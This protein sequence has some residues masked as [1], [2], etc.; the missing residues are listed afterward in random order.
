MALHL[1]TGRRYTAAAIGVERRTN[2]TDARPWVR[3]YGT[4]PAHLDYPEITLYE[5]LARTAQRVPHAIAWDFFDTTSTFRQL[6]ADIDHFADALAATGLKRGERMLISM[7]TSPQGVIAFY[8]ANKLGAVA[9]VIHPLST[10]PEIEGYLDASRARIALTL[11]AFYER[12]ASAQPRV[13]L[14]SLVLARIPDYL[15]PRQEDRLLADQ[16][17]QDPDGAR[18]LARPLVGR[19]DGRSAIRRRRARSMSTDEPAVILFSGGTTGAPKGIVPLEP[20][21]HRRGHAGCRVVRTMGEGRFDPRALIPIFH[22]F[23][24]GVCVNALFMAGG[25]S[26]SFLASRQRGREPARAESAR[27]CSSACPRSSTR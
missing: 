9:A 3:F 4:V 15:G 16:G 2:M 26:S 21:L 18:R 23:G 24:L 10:V 7:P 6:L 11:D 14:E 27:R 5:A 1:R 19:S 22:G 20:Q 8:A 13:R 17:P 25:K 12:F